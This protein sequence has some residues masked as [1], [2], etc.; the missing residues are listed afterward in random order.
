MR[1]YGGK[2]RGAHEMGAV[3]TPV[4]RDA[5]TT[6][7]EGNSWC[8]ADKVDSNVAVEDSWGWQIPRWRGLR[9][10]RYLASRTLAPSVPIGRATGYGNLNG[11]A[12]KQLKQPGMPSRFLPRYH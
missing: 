1:R 11:I 6:M 8:R 5:Q 7:E 2:W 9:W 3:K 4:E 10:D 12:I